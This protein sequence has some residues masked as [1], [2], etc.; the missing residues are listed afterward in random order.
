[1]AIAT[2]LSSCNSEQFAYVFDMGD[3][4]AHLCTVTDKHIDPADELGET[5]ASRTSTRAAGTE[6]TG[7]VAHAES[8]RPSGS[9]TCL[10]PCR[11]GEERRR[12]T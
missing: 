5:E 2:K 11:G 4:W 9:V 10:R 3:D 1:M 6:T 12:G 7:G 8:G